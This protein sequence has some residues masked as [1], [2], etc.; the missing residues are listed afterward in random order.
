MIRTTQALWLS[1]ALLADAGVGS[2]GGNARATLVFSVADCSCLPATVDVEIQG[3]P[4]ARIDLQCGRSVP[5]TVYGPGSRD[6]RVSQGSVVW[7]DERYNAFDGDEVA[8]R[9]SC[10]RR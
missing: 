4:P 7:H 9:M 10:P 8:V 5:V 6:V 2:C 1:G 3:E